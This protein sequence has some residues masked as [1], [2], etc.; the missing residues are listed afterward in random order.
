MKHHY[1][2][3]HSRLRGVRAIA[4]SALPSGSLSPGQVLTA[5]G[6]KQNQ[7][8]G[9]LPVKLGIGS[10]GGGVVQADLANASK[11]W[12]MPAP[13]VTVRTVGGAANDPVS[14]QDSNVENMLD[15][16]IIAFTW[17]FLTG[18]PADVTITFGPNATGGME[19]VTRDLISAGVEVGSW[20]WGAAASSWDAHERASLAQVF[21]NASSAAL[22]FCSASGD[23]SIDDG[24]S[25]P[26]A[27]YPCA[28]PHV[29]AV[30]GTLLTV[31]PGGARAS[32]SAWGDGKPGDEGG[33]GGFDP[34]VPVP[35]WQK[36]ALPA[37][38]PGRGVPDT[39]ANADPNSGWQISANG[40]W[41]VV[42]GT[43]AAS[44]FTAA[45]VA[46]AKGIAKS[47][48]DGLT[49]PAIYAA[50]GACNDVVK[51]SDGVPATSGW[52]E[53]TGLGSPNGDKFVQAIATWAKGHAPEPPA[54][55]HPHPPVPPPLPHP[56][57]PPPPTLESGLYTKFDVIG[58]AAEGI[59]TNWSE[60]KP[61]SLE[62]AQKWAAD[63]IEFNWPVR[64]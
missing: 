3:I 59:V 63:G 20:S 27:D 50:P 23:N 1:H 5:Y 8:S 24:T 44:P 7:Y 14:D 41:T 4:P 19:E 33:G 36:T 38:A 10:L 61:V 9:A 28:D 58:W 55:P 16:E 46:V 15:L 40:A 21:A 47:L 29:W 25:K 32:E 22:C 35:A 2:R 18:T 53:A 42:G 60:D 39:S 31:G 57:A 17:W 45:L 56:P 26:S 52:D 62:N 43:S 6:F 49:T 13:H 37:S 30:G 34:T 54:P 64:R 12:G 51:G 11:A 48:G